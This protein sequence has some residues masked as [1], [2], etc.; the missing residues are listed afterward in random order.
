[1]AD[2]QPFLDPWDAPF[3][4]GQSLGR[5]EI[6]KKTVAICPSAVPQGSMLSEAQ[7]LGAKTSKG[8]QVIQSSSGDFPMTTL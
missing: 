7:R 3:L 2:Q 8:S 1:M 4:R 6:P 5:L